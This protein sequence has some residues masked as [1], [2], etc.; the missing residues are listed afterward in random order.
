M[1]E[2]TTQAC[3]WRGPLQGLRVLDFTRVLAGPFATLLLADQGAEVIKVESP[4]G[5]DDTRRFPPFRGPLS[6]YFTAMNR[7]KQSVVLDLRSE[8]GRAVARDLAARSDVVIENFRPGVMA[9]LGLDYERLAAA[10]PGLI[11]CAISGFGADGPLRDKPSFDI[12]TQAL[13]G[14]MSVNGDPDGPPAKLGLPMGDMVGGIY[15]AI[16]V[17]SALHERTVTGRG[18]FIDIALLDGM[19]GM[20]GYLA[21]IHFVTGK[22]PVRVGTRHPNLVPYGAYA[23][24]DGHVII[25]CLTEGFWHNLARCIGREDLLADPRF[26][27]Y[28]SRL[29]HRQALEAAV[30]QVLLT[31]TTAE[32]IKR[33]ERF[34]VPHAPILDVGQALEHPNTRTRGM[35]TSALHPQLGEIPMVSSPVRYGDR[36][37]PR[38]AAPP[39]LGENTDA[40]LERVLGL[41]AEARAALRAGGVLG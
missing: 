16:A 7:N 27:D 33:L 24:A 26:A 13:S 12:V 25:A 41:D 18:R 11:Y 38:P 29:Q 19:L 32:W 40:V 28:P 10:N 39:L 4:D 36:E 8:A 5:G 22:P 3:E 37:R 2:A 35:V 30:G 1:T 14:V 6:H 21:Q 34:D 15:G 31:R 17:L 23:T 20:L 9:R